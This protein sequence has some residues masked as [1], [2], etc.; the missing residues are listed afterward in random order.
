MMGNLTLSSG[1]T[2][3]TFHFLGDYNVNDFHIASGA[4]TIIQHA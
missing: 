4:T 1:G 2:T 3:N